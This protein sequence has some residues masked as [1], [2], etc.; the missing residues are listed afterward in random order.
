MIKFIRILKKIIFPI[1]LL[2]LVTIVSI[3]VTINAI[4]I[5]LTNNN[6]TAIYAAVMIPITLVFIALYIADRLLIKR[7]SYVKLILG[8]IVIGLSVFFMFLYLNRTTDINFLTNQDYI[9]IVFDSKEN[10]LS[11]LSKKRIFGKELNVYNTNIVHLESTMALRKDLRVNKPKEWKNFIEYRSVFDIEGDSIAY[12][13]VSK[14]MLNPD[15]EMHS[16]SY[17]DSLLNEVK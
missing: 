8:E 12:I 9:L 16:Q 17:I 14:K 7:V 3:I 2:T 1:T 13:F 10:S 11:K 5:T 15:Y 6:E 4:Y